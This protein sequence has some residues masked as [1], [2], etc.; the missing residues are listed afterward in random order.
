MALREDFED[1]ESKLFSSSIS[2]LSPLGDELEKS[3]VL[4]SKSIDFSENITLSLKEKQWL[5]LEVERCHDS[6]LH[7]LEI[8][9]TDAFAVLQ[10]VLLEKDAGDLSNFSLV[11]LHVGH[12]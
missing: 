7:L 2:S 8:A 1:V 9:W 11:T 4:S 3:L 12:E 5:C 6:F 10:E